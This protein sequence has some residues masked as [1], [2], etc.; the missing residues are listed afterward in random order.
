MQ[1]PG[2]IPMSEKSV[3]LTYNFGDQ[4]AIITGGGRG[5][6]RAFAQA[7]AAAGTKVALIARTE[8]E[9]KITVKLIEAL[10]RNSHLLPW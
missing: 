4:V 7:L 9:L 5:L 6:G 1:I 8:E 3:G 10:G 2:G